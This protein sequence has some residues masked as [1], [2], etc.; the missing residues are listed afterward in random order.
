MLYSM[1]CD[2]RVSKID[3]TFVVQTEHI[4]SFIDRV[5]VARN[6][7]RNIILDLDQSKFLSDAVIAQLVVDGW[8]TLLDNFETIDSDLVSQVL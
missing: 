1:K 5:R 7:A 2:Q 3:G 8:R 4:A 6:L